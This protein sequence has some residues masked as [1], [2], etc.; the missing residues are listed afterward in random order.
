MGPWK[1]HGMTSLTLIHLLILGLAFSIV[2]VG[3]LAVALLVI[4]L[5]H[6]RASPANLV[7][8]PDCS[9]PVSQLAANCPHCGSPLGSMR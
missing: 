1:E 8:R 6:R 9:R 5:F 2:F 4:L 7:P 3:P